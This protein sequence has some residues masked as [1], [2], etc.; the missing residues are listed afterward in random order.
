MHLPT[1]LYGCPMALWAGLRRCDCR[2]QF[3]GADHCSYNVPNVWCPDLRNKQSRY[4]P[5]HTNGMTQRPQSWHYFLHARSTPSHSW[6]SLMCTHCMHPVSCAVK[7][8]ASCGYRLRLLVPAGDAGG[9]AGT[10]YFA[11]C[12]KWEQGQRSAAACTA[13]GAMLVR[14]GS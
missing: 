12:T 4:Y 5:F 10:E 11:S 14:H 9:K 13:G 6:T 3:A 8:P 1:L 7:P 2:C